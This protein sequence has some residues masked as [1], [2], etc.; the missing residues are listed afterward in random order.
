[1]SEPRYASPDP[2]R[3]ALPP[4]VAVFPQ[5]AYERYD[6]A[7]LAR[8]MIGGELPRPPIMELLGLRDLEIEERRS[9]MAM[10]TN[11]WLCWQRRDRLAP[12]PWRC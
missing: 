7:T 9:S 4:G 5:G 8:K 6:G 1:M 10:P 2:H 3:R 12:A 11:D